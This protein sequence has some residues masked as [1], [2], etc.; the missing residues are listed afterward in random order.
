MV[1]QPL[2]A[3]YVNVH[4]HR[5]AYVELGEGDPILFLHGNPTSSYLWRAVMPEVMKRGRC[6]AP[7][8]IGMGRSDK[9]E[10]P[11]PD[12]YRFVTHRK[13]IEGFIDALGVGQNLTLVVHDWGSALGFDW[14]CRHPS[15]VRAMVY[16]EAIVRPL[17]DWSE[18]AQ[19]A[20]PI[21]Q[22]LRT[23]A[24][25]QMIQSKN[26][27]IE[28][29]L[30]G[31]IIRTL[32]DEEMAVYRAPYSNAQD[33]WPTLTWPREI[34]FGGEPAD[35]A[36]IVAAYAE[37]MSKSEMPKLFVNAKPGGILTGAQREFCRGWKNQEEITVAG[38]H[39]IQEDSGAEI[40]RAIEAWMERALGAPSIRT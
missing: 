12:T 18:W 9:L 38:I 10:N 16:M 24:G 29:V 17:A 35:V 22:G 4:G 21:F 13:Y 33:R 28:N 19:P 27:F 20:V 3:R 40:G 36:K 7:D 34:P 6:I 37:W 30:P 26:V 39:Y 25:E 31:A 2:P 14:A 32:T 11:G 5:M 23:P 15:S 8:L 1:D